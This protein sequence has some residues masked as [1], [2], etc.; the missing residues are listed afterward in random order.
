MGWM[1]GYG[2]MRMGP[3][4]S[5]QA[6]QAN[7]SVHTKTN[8]CAIVPCSARGE[9]STR[10]GEQTG[11]RKG[12]GV[13]LARRRFKKPRTGPRQVGTRGAMVQA[14]CQDVIQSVDRTRRSGS[15]R[16]SGGHGDGAGVRCD[17]E[18]F[19][20]ICI[21]IDWKQRRLPSVLAQKLARA[22]VGGQ[23]R[24]RRDSASGSGGLCCCD[25]RCGGLLGL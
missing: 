19:L 17:I 18:G 25:T 20:F 10:T 4:S 9:G 22:A 21:S 7:E 3:G 8:S 12:D 2:Y 1:Y 24:R 11:G 6:E 14:P 23:G 16:D 5:R 13:F 15:G